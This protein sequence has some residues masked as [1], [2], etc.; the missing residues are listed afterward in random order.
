MPDYS[1][2]KLYQIICHVTGKR[3]VGST[4]KTLSERLNG[5]NYSK[6]KWET[7]GTGNYCSS[8]EVL[9]HG[10]YYIELIENF[11][12]ET[13]LELLKRERYWTNQ[14][15]CVNKHTQQGLKLEIGLK[16][17]NKYNHAKYRLKHSE[18]I[19]E[20]SRNYYHNNKEK[21]SIKNKTYKNINKEHVK[22]IHLKSYLKNRTKQQAKR[23]AKVLCDC[24]TMYAHSHRSD[25]IKSKLHLEYEDLSELQK[26]IM[27]G[28]KLIKE[29]DIFFN[30]I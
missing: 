25:H 4:C 18:E 1:Q 2:G 7:Y 21:I 11:P 26:I 6:R 9:E 22:Q 23:S 20:K 13:K 8:Y 3:Y 28:L 19:N 30:S 29:L 17:Y 14:I 27:K 16:E 15:E 12:C 24:G 10:D 5:H